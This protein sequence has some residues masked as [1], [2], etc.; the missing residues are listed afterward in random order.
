ML[1]I[2]FAPSSS[3]SPLLPH[4]LFFLP[5]PRLL[6]LP[7]SLLFSSSFPSPSP[8]PSLPPSLLLSPF[9]ATRSEPVLRR[10][11][12][13]VLV[14]EPARR[15]PAVP[16]RT[17]FRGWQ[18]LGSQKRRFWSFI[19]VTASHRGG[20]LLALWGASS[21]GALGARGAHRNKGPEGDPVVFEESITRFSRGSSFRPEFA[22]MKHF[23]ST[24]QVRRRTFISVIHPLARGPSRV[25]EGPRA[26]G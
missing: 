19:S 14:T 17:D 16:Q 25:P 21:G 4:H 15:A 13:C 1:P 9:V 18:D 6:P 22:N 3:S 8:P 5:L 11:E 7:L 12:P 23:W 10:V 20:W 2:A 24:P 26:R